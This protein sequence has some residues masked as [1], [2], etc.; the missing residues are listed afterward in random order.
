M[1]NPTAS[2]GPDEDLALL[3]RLVQNR[4]C[5]EVA[6]P[7]GSCVGNCRRLVAGDADCTLGLSDWR[8]ASLDDAIDAVEALGGRRLRGHADEERGFIQ[9]EGTL[10]GVREH[11]DVLADF[12][13]AGGGRVLVATGHP[14][15]LPHYAAV[16]A[17]LAR[18]GCLLLS[19]LADGREVTTTSEGSS[20]SVA[21]V[22]GVAASYHDGSVRHTHRAEYMES[23]LDE[24]GS[25]LPD[26]VVGDH[27]FAGAAIEAGIATLSIAD[28]NDPALPLAQARNRTRGVLLVDD[29]LRPDL[30]AP[31]SQA[32]LGWSEAG[33]RRPAS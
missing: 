2:T 17:A 11:H 16:A 26:L 23:M 4:L 1:G 27:G 33:P 31:V 8:T 32:I 6:T 14:V 24:L 3:E 28:V 21:Y 15:L 18:A 20:G 9:P 10:A 12:V 30:F 25:G 13:A 19:P 29:G 5:G 7:V 22:D